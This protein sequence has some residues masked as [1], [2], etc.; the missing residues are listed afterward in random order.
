MKNMFRNI[1]ILLISIIM[2]SC[3]D[4]GIVNHK[5]TVNVS[6][7]EG[8]IVNP[9]SG[10]YP[11]ETVVKLEATPSEGYLFKEWVG[12]TSENKNPMYLLMDSDKS[13]T[14]IFEKQVYVL[15]VEIEG[16]GFVN[17]ESVQADNSVESIVKLSAVP[18]SGWEFKE[19]GADLSGTE[20]PTQIVLDKNKTAKAIFSEIEKEFNG[21]KIESYTF[22]PSTI[23]I[24]NNDVVVTVK[25]HVTDESGIKS[26]PVVYIEHPDNATG[27]Q[28]TNNLQLESG[29]NKDGIYSC[30]IT[31]PQDLQPGE[32]KVFSN[33]FM[34]VHDNSSGSTIFP[35]SEKKTLTVINEND[36]D[37]DGPTIESFTFSPSSIDITNNDV[38]VTVKAHVT[39]ASG[40][41]S[42][43][44]VYIEHPDNAT[45]TQQ[46][47][48]LQLESGTNKDGI[49]SCDITIPQGLQPGEW[50]VFANPFMDIHD[51]SSVSSIQPTS[52]KK[53]LTVINEND[54][55][56]DG[57]TIKSF[58]FS[59]NSIDITNNDVVVTVKA[60]VT[61]AS[62]V[63]S[64]P[65]VYIEHPDNAT[66]TQQTNNLQLESGTNKDGIYSC[67]ITIPQGLQPGEWRVFANPFMDIHDNSSISSIQPTSEK[68][69]LTVVSN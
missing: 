47:E 39:D 44:V 66:G 8:G 4:E 6:P 69:T 52:E 18:N 35:T 40:V 22:T 48:N 38:V 1:I 34:D 37:F 46:T 32:W 67:E 15:T 20:N 49:Y 60:H 17:Q 28:Q 53:T 31:I 24:T 57:P 54:S 55:D 68:K 2:I 23:D 62:G 59:P 11:D 29:T 45:G 19:W 21:P 25:A 36:S 9:S 33:P 16:E 41:K 65:V 58:T 64:A 7:Q 43:P 50:R 5:L 10:N 27:T 13:I 63:K 61:D 42:A 14:A 3:S 56:F 30:D 12:V 51:N 26:A